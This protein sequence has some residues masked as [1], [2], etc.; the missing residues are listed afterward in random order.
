MEQRVSEVMFG[1]VVG[2][3]WDSIGSIGA[4]LGQ[5]WDLGHD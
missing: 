2:Q 3:D 5:H 1:T 4:A